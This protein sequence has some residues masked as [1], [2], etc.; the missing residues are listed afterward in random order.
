M[1]DALKPAL[2]AT[3]DIY[4]DGSQHQRTATRRLFVSGDDPNAAGSHPRLVRTER[5]YT[6]GSRKTFAP[7]VYPVATG[8]T[9]AATK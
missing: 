1:A 8:P 7:V 2:V 3:I 9:G 6:D 4:D 5:V